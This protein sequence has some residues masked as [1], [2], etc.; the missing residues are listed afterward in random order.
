MKKNTSYLT[1][2][3]KLSVSGDFLVNVTNYIKAVGYADCLKK[4][5]ALTNKRWSDKQE[6]LLLM[7]H[8]HEMSE[9]VYKA[10][11]ET[12]ETAYNSDIA[13]ASALSD[14][15]PKFTMTEDMLNL[16]F[17]VKD[18][19]SYLQCSEKTASWILHHMPT[20][21]DSSLSNRMNHERFID[22][23]KLEKW[24]IR[25]LNIG[26]EKLYKQYGAENVSDR[27]FNYRSIMVWNEKKKIYQCKPLNITIGNICDCLGIQESTL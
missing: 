2:S 15:L 25:L 14:L 21:K 7:L 18:L 5:T 19:Q 22:S 11:F 24:Y 10:E 17:T 20:C 4:A 12:Y 3:I 27:S 6:E 23:V 26:A 9:E 8:D 13:K 1:D 16:R